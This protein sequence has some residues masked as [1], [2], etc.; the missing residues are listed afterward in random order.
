MPDAARA[1]AQITQ[2]GY[3]ETPLNNQCDDTSHA[4]SR[5][6]LLRRMAAFVGARRPPPPQNQIECFK[7]TNVPASR[8]AP[9]A[10]ELEALRWTMEGMT[11]SEIGIKLGL[12]DYEVAARLRSAMRKLEC[13]TKYEAVLK[14]I[15][16]R[17]IEGPR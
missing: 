4:R 6:S 7:S 13:K 3:M 5:P 17:L 8:Q 14:A 10:P 9:T 1:T 2:R 11:D 15:K 16:L 12:P